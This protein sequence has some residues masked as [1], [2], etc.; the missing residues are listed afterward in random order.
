VSAGKANKSLLLIKNGRNSEREWRD[1][2]VCRNGTR[3][4]EKKIEK[5]KKMFFKHK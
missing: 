3:E 5:K 2:A 1:G 4:K